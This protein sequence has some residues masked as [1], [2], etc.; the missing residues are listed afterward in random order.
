MQFENYVAKMLIVLK[1]HRGNNFK[2][3]N[4]LNDGFL[5]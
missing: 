1:V 4:E 5:I 2:K 3:I